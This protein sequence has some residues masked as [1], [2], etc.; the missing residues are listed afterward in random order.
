MTPNSPQPSAQ[1]RRRS[2]KL[3][4]LAALVGVIALTACDTMTLRTTL[5][6]TA[7]NQA[8]QSIDISEDGLTMAVGEIKAR[9][10]TVADAG[11]VSVYVRTSTTASWTR[12]ATLVA[13][14]PDKDSLYGLAVA[15]SANGSRLV[16][17]APEFGNGGAAFVYTRTNETWDDG[18]SLRATTGGLDYFGSSVAVSGDGDVVAVG[19]RRR[20]IVKG[21]ITYE[22]AGRVLMYEF[23]G[24]GWTVRNP[25]IPSIPQENAYFGWSV[26]LSANGSELI[27]GAPKHDTYSDAVKAIVPD[28]GRIEI[29]KRSGNIWSYGF[30]LTP[31]ADSLGEGHLMGHSL[32]MSGDDS[33]IAVGVP[34]IDQTKTDVGGM[35]VFA[36]NGN[37]WDKVTY[38]ASSGF[39]NARAGS[40]IAVSSDGSHVLVGLPGYENNVGAVALLEKKNGTYGLIEAYGDTSAD[41]AGG[42]LGTSVA[43]SGNEA[44]WVAGMPGASSNAGGYRAFDS[45]AVPG[46]PTSP[47]ATAG[48]GA[49]LVQWTAPADNGGLPL[50]SSVVTSTPG[51]KTCTTAGSSCLVTGL[52]NGTAYTFKVVARNAIGLGASSAA[53]AA[54]T[55]LSGSTALAGLGG[56]PLAPTLVTVAAGWKRATVSWQAAVSVGQ[57]I[58]SYEV[59]AS[60]GGKTCS[61]ASELTCTI[62]GLAAR[63]K[64]TFSV[65]ASNAFGSG[66]AGTSERTA[67]QPKVSLSTGPTSRTLAAWLGIATGIGETTSMR[68][69]GKAAKANC[70]IVDGKLI[71]KVAGTQCKVTVKSRYLRTLSRTLFIQTVRR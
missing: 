63:K 22:G 43:I 53:T 49:A 57:A 15:L 17:G 4:S 20:D 36:R 6:S 44:V 64:Y 35:A 23:V 1:R 14:S 28:T 8:G 38:T 70:K 69:R 24:T 18:V 47:V 16:V 12:Q 55:P 50:T 27:V 61:T 30:L 56:A 46:A 39:E 51:G 29:A 54:V 68:L 26:A 25:V 11:L 13:Q 9:A 32:A 65:V 33:T 37:G 21:G 59:T 40:S 60:P 66:P 31:G 42:K 58:Q 3:A 71:A 45:F 52:D 48:G 19:Q 5:R 67:L 2:T 41:S 7:G 10:R 34:G 62:T